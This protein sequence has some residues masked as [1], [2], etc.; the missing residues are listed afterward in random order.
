M[1][2]NIPETKQKRIAIIGGGFGG[3]TLVHG[4]LDSNYQIILVD[5][6]NYHQFQPLFYQIATAELE[7]SSISFPFRK[8]F[9]RNKNIHIRM[10]EVFSVN[11]QRNSINTGI[12]K[13]DYDFLVIA[14]G[15]NTNFFG[16]KKIQTYSLP[17]KSVGEALDIRNKVLENYEKALT[18]TD[19]DEQQALMNIAVVGGGPTGVE[20]SG[21]L[22]EM[23]IYILPKDYSELDFKNMQ[24]FLIE[25]SS[26]LLSTMSDI[27][28]QKAE[29]YL[30]RLN[31]K[32]LTNTSVK[33]YDGKIITLSNG[34]RLHAKNLVWAAGVIGNKLEGIPNEVFVRNNRI[35]VDGFNKVEGLENIYAIGHIAFMTE[36]RYPNGHPQ[37]AQTAIQQAKRL[38]TNLRNME[39]KKVLEPFHYKDFGSLAT[40]GKNLA[41]ADLPYL[42]FQGLH[43]LRGYLFILWQL[44]G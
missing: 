35:K 44:W 30:K 18:T 14:M 6:N 29:L 27:A 32:L 7:P 3:L 24:I 2:S 20:V 40:I 5:K 25:T 12:G 33:D 22:A 15:A 37:V 23:K 11:I 4:L 26:K 31:V 39:G 43:G 16:N 17:M 28:S 34:S 21:T 42:K 36:D 19:I 13:I 10:T 41:V 1:N 8:I 38:A 9:Q